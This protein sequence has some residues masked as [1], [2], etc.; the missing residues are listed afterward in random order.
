[1]LIEVLL[2]GRFAEASIRGLTWRGK[3]A[4]LDM[5]RVDV[6][7]IMMI[8]GLKDAIRS[9]ARQLLCVPGRI[10]VVLCL[11]IQAIIRLR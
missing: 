1:M 10:F 7:L 2:L 8:S 3:R 6:R 5:T 9:L 11:G 4:E